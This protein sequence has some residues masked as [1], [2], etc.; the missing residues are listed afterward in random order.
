MI[1][2]TFKIKQKSATTINFF[3]RTFD[4]WIIFP[5]FSW[6]LLENTDEVIGS[7]LD[8]TASK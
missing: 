1:K 5:Y 8:I 3:I 4:T 2:T 7:V 6:T